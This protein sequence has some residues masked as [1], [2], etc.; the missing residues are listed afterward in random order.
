M[1]KKINL[2]TESIKSEHFEVIGVRYDAINTYQDFI[3]KC[4]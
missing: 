3:E 1:T 4:K 2:I